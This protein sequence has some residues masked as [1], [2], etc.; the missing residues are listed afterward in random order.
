MEKKKILALLLAGAIGLSSSTVFAESYYTE[1]TPLE[2]SLVLIGEVNSSTTFHGSMTW[3]EPNG[4]VQIQAITYANVAGMPGEVPEEGD[5]AES[6]ITAIEDGSCNI[7]QT[8][9]GIELLGNN[10]TLKGV[11]FIYHAYH[12]NLSTGGV[13]YVKYVSL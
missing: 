2:K 8:A 1:L 12:D 6:C 11:E 3:A 13:T 7:N 9:E 5:E 4:K 10:Y